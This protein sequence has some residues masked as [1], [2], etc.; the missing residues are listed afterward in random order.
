MLCH[1]NKISAHASMFDYRNH[2][3]IALSPCIRAIVV[4]A[5]LEIIYNSRAISQSIRRVAGIC[6]HLLAKSAPIDTEYYR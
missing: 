5:H 1:I 2:Q 4:Y 3:S 6:R